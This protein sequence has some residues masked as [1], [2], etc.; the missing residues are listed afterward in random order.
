MWLLKEKLSP[1]FTPLDFTCSVPASPEKL[2]S[3]GQKFHCKDKITIAPNSVAV[4][5]VEKERL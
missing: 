3:S 4:F 2:A 5:P 1:L